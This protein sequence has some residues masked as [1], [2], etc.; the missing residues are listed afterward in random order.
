MEKLKS[1]LLVDK[2]SHIMYWFEGV[3]V[4]DHHSLK[5]ILLWTKFFI[6]STV[7]HISSFKIPLDYHKMT[8]SKLREVLT[9]IVTTDNDGGKLMS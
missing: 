4:L 1:T 6:Y 3:G 9:K 8:V 5:I 7:D 2:I